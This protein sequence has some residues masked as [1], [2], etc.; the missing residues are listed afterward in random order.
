[1]K[2]ILEYQFCKISRKQYFLGKISIV[3]IDRYHA[4][5]YRWKEVLMQK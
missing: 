1:M 4:I 3:G 5:C 2:C